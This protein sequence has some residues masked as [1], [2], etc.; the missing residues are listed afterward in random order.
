M[1]KKSHL[2]IWLLL[3]GLAAAMGL[4]LLI[5]ITTVDERKALEA[6]WVVIIKVDGAEVARLG[7]EEIKAA[8]E[9]NFNC[10]MDTSTTGPEKVNFTGV[11]LKKLLDDHRIYQEGKGKVTCTA[12]DNYASAFSME[13]LQKEGNAYLC[14]AR[15]GQ[16]LGT[17]AEGGMG[18]YL[19]VLTQDTFSSR[20]CKYLMEIDIH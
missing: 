4:L 8:G 15:D 17:K 3:G 10:I 14:Y 11:P 19:V 18:P 20:W 2:T 1:M 6:N 9:V 16:P 12:L 13:E 7:L 5:N